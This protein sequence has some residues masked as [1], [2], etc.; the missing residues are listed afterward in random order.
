VSRTRAIFRSAEL[1]F[2]GVMVRTC[3]QTP[4][5]CGEPLPRTSL[6]FSVLYVKRSASDFVFLAVRFRPGGNVGQASRC[7]QGFR[8]TLHRPEQASPDFLLAAALRAY[9]QMVLYPARLARREEARNQS[10]QLLS[11][12]L[13]LV[14]GWFN[15][16]ASARWRSSSSPRCTRVLTVESGR[17]NKRAISS[18][19]MSS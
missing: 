11:R 8:D 1:G 17:P 16:R 19:P 9:G 5:F 13:V 3:V 15:P 7:G 12:L 4:R 6:F 14:H 2:L 18:M 10:G